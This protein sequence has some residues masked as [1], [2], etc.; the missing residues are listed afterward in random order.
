MKADGMTLQE[1]ADR[2]TAEGVPTLGGVR[3][4]QPWSVRAATRATTPAHRPAPTGR[5][6]T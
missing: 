5:R 1:I 2:L 4:W 6:R 3:R